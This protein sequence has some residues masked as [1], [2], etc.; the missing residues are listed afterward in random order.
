MG[1]EETSETLPPSGTLSLLI[2]VSFE[3]H[4]ALYNIVHINWSHIS[5]YLF[6]FLFYTPV[7][8]SFLT[9]AGQK[10]SHILAQEKKI[11]TGFS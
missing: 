1:L 11:S 8:S 3:Q 9:H 4:C 6:Y 2:S 5:V 7:S 10:Q